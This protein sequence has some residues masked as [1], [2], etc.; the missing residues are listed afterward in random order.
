[1]RQ[2][3]DLRVRAQNGNVFFD[4]LKRPLTVITRL[5]RKCLGSRLLSNARGHLLHFGMHAAI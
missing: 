3:N 2:S 1:M 5:V 4:A